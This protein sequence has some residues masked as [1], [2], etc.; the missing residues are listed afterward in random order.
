LTNPEQVEPRQ[1]LFELGIDSLM[2]VEL[3]NHLQS[4]LNHSIDSTI[5]FNYPNLSELVDYLVSDVL[6]IEFPILLDDAK[7]PNDQEGQSLISEDLEKLSESD[8]EVLLL[9]KLE[10]IN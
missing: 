2:A 4:S 3:R 10:N 5:L 8:A 9:E 6:S 1:S 7:T